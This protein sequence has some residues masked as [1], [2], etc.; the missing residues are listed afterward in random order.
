M[1]DLNGQ[2]ANATGACLDCVLRN[3]IEGPCEL[4]SRL[5]LTSSVIIS[6]CFC[7]LEVCHGI[8]TGPVRP[9]SSH[10]YKNEAKGMR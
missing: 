2:R 5:V 9:L 4:D 7:P 8:R 1:G 10:V 6:D 3:E